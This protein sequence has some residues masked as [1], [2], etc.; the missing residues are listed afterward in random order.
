MVE[1]FAHIHKTFYSVVKKVP[2]I[3]RLFFHKFPC[4]YR[5]SNK[6]FKLILFFVDQF[7]KKVTKNH[8]NKFCENATCSNTFYQLSFIRPFKLSKSME[9][10]ILIC[11]Y[12]SFKY[13]FLQFLQNCLT[14]S[15]HIIGP[16]FKQS[17]N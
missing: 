17:P 11:T 13:V 2:K 6:I 4:F 5:L 15:V 1:F 3:K 14:D 8:F 12:S 7:S 10:S 16:F 9:I